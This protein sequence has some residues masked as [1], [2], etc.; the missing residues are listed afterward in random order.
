M[1]A[2]RRPLGEARGAAGELDVDGVVELQRAGER[3]HPV[4]LGRAGERRD[5]VEVVHAGGD[6]AAEAHD[7]L[8]MRQLFR[9]QP[10]GPGPVELRRDLAQHVDIAA[11]L[12][13]F[14]GHQRPA[15]HLV[16]R[17]FELGEGDRRD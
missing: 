8:E 7:G 5:L 10:A 2:E 1:V 17:V 4:A 15:L 16:E 12:E 6:F 11:R 3:V 14:G 13:R 9:L